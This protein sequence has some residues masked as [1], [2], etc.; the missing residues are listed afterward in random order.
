M[1]VVDPQVRMAALFEP[2]QLLIL[3]CASLEE[4]TALLGNGED[5][6]FSVEEED[7][8]VRTD[9]FDGGDGL[10]LIDIGAGVAV[11]LPHNQLQNREEGAIE[12]HHMA[13]KGLREGNIAAFGYQT[14][15]IFWAVLGFQRKQAGGGA[16]ANAV[17][18]D[19]PVVKTLMNQFGPGQHILAFLYADGV[20]SS[21]T[22]AVAAGIHYQHIESCLLIGRGEIIG[23]YQALAA[24]GQ[25][26]YATLCAKIK[27][28]SVTAVKT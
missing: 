19:L 3:G 21:V 5:I 6:L 22:K 10:L 16:D 15:Q 17:E 1:G 4:L 7:A 14:L 24:A 11:D 8:A 20:V 25:N 2:N 18:I 23:V 28:S 13:L 12:R 26:D 9:L 27:V